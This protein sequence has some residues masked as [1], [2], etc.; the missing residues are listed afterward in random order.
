ME[1]MF[2]ACHF[3]EQTGTFDLPKVVN[4]NQ[5]YRNTGWGNYTDVK[6]NAYAQYQKMAASP[7]VTTHSMTFNNCPGNERIP[8]DWGGWGM[9]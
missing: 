3:L 9:S 2:Y 5:V 1:Q 8:Q 4:C 7:Y 6:I